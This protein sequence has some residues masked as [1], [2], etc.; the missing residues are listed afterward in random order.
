MAPKAQLTNVG[1]VY[2]ADYY[3][4]WEL[5]AGGKH[6]EAIK[7][8][9]D[10]Y[11]DPAIPSSLRIMVCNI[12]AES[13]EGDFVGFAEEAV[14]LAEKDLVSLELLEYIQLNIL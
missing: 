4:L 10:L 3:T 8:A 9:A 5:S 7:L 6:S 1:L 14:M 13:D 12:L 2:R 11:M